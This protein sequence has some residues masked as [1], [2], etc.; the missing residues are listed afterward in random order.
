MKV[1]QTGVAVEDPLTE[2][3]VC[4]LSGQRLWKQAAHI[5]TTARSRCLCNR[6]RNRGKKKKTNMKQKSSVG[7]PYINE[8]SNCF[9]VRNKEVFVFKRHS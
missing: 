8:K 7:A 3:V 6:R 9:L 1:G 5:V 2:P 4:R